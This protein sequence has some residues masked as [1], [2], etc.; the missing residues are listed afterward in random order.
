MKVDYDSEARSLLFEFG[1]FG[2]D[3][4][5]EE[6]STGECIVWVLEGRP[7]SIQLLNAD[8]DTEVLEEAAARFQL[9]P[10]VL[11]AA[12][13]A[14]LAAPDREITIEVGRDLAVERA[15]AEAEAA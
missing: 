11:K 2:K 5:V 10:A 3:D 7:N 4:Y 1:E 12:A 8:T 9:D 15:A 13:H 14:A 6:L